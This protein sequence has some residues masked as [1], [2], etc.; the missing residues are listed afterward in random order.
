MNALPYI[1]IPPDRDSSPLVISVP[2]AGTRV[3]AQDAPLIN[4]TD[5]QR[6]MDADLHVDRLYRHGPNMGTHLIRCT[7]DRYVL[8]VNRAADDVGPTAC[9]DVG[10]A[11]PR[12]QGLIWTHTT[13]GDSILDKPLTKA[14]LDDRI[15]RVHTPYHTKLREVLDAVKAKFGYAIL[16][17]AHSMPSVGRAMHS[18]LGKTRPHVVP[19]DNHGKSCDPALTALVVEHFQAAD[20]NV[21]TNSPYS[22]GYITQN[23]GQ[24]DD[25]VH[26]IQIEFSRALYLHEEVPYWA[27]APALEL[28][29][30][31]TDLI[32]KLKGWK[33][34]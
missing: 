8:D 19:G 25:G 17:D 33:P 18:D 20:L 22:G 27:G 23:Y 15:A 31:V 2:H 13:Y 6:L 10:R 14:Q 4:A 32:S 1:Y 16:L 11:R 29:R 26:A 7:I 12:P 24:P 5:T 3:P 30:L 9:P 21:A 28:E 34:S